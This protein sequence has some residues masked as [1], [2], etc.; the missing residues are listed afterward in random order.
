MA[1]AHLPFEQYFINTS[2]DFNHTGRATYDVKYIPVRYSCNKME[3]LF[4]DFQ[5][6]VFAGGMDSPP[7]DFPEP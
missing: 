5:P 2:D 1:Y 7:L 4:R 3:K 6:A